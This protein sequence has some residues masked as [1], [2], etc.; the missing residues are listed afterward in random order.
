M[1][2]VLIRNDEMVLEI[3]VPQTVIDLSDMQENEFDEFVKNV[4]LPMFHTQVTLEIDD[5]VKFNNTTI[6][7]IDNEILEWID[8][9]E[10]EF[11]KINKDNLTD[12]ERE[13]FEQSEI[14]L[15]FEELIGMLA[16]MEREDQALFL[17]GLPK[18]VREIILNNAELTCN[19]DDKEKATE[20]FE[21][22]KQEILEAPEIDLDILT[23]SNE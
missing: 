12:E 1:D 9:I 8:E 21:I 11:E 10:T 2:F 13:K 20:L 14:S 19:D 18:Q 4:V 3:K 7:T 17:K 15:I 5:T 23:S 16:Q 6:I 22:W